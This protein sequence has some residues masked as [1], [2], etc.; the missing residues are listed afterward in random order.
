MIEIPSLSETSVLSEGLMKLEEDLKE[1]FKTRIFSK[2]LLLFYF[3]MVVN[4]IVQKL[5]VMQ[6]KSCFQAS[7]HAVPVP[8]PADD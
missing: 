7:F 6:L 5:K 8:V 4:S 1:N 2:I 3:C